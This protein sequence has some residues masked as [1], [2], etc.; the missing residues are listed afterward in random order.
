MNNL[1]SLKGDQEFVYK[2]W[3]KQKDESLLH[4]EKAYGCYFEDS[5][6]KKYLDFAAQ[7][8]SVN[9]GHDH[10]KITASIINQTLNLNGVNPSFS[11]K[12]KNL[13]GEKISKIL[14]GDLNK[15][16]FTLA[17]TDAIE[18]S[19]KIARMYTG[20]KKVISR[21]RSYHGSSFGAMAVSGDPRRHFF[22]PDDSWVIRVPD[23]YPYRSPIY[24]DRSKE[25]G[26]E[27]LLQMM[28]DII[29]LEDPQQ[30]G[31]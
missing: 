29:L 1:N 21:Y 14:P 20:K 22:S 27:V 31:A 5:E 12:N 9:A 8:S 25:E 16:F 24:S 17:G 6:G 3:A 10:P 15:T 30:I 28:E 18:N 7:L 13:L 23:P 4:I 26:D 19:L 11:H 2:T